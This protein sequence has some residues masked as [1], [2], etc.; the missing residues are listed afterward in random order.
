MALPT[1]RTNSSSVIP[2]ARVRLLALPPGGKAIAVSRGFEN[3]SG[4]I[5]VLSDVRQDFDPDALQ[6]W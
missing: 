2:D 5:I 3:V 1:A 4:E 6:L